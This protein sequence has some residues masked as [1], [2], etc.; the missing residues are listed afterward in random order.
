MGF[1]FLLILMVHFKQTTVKFYINS[2]DH[3]STELKAWASV[4]HGLM[5]GHIKYFIPRAYL[6]L[7]PCFIVR[8]EESC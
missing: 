7:V 3:E 1:S 6:S 4:T 8:R 5:S 2:S